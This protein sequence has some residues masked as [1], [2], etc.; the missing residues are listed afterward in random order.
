[1]QAYYSLFGESVILSVNQEGG[2]TKFSKP[3]LLKQ[4]F[5][6]GENTNPLP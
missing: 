3:C 4:T 2:E 5:R 1:M 6:L